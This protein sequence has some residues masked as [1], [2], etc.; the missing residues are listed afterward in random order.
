MAREKQRVAQGGAYQLGLRLTLPGVAHG[1]N[2][3]PLG[4]PGEICLFLSFLICNMGIQKVNHNYA[5]KVPG[6]ESVTH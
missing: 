3:Y 2:S 6:N 4:S 1:S 5:G